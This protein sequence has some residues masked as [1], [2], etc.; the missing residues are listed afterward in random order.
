MFREDSIRIVDVIQFIWEHRAQVCQVCSGVLRQ[1]GR[2]NRGTE[3]YWI[4]KFRSARRLK[5]K[6]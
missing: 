4:P 3:F 6:G 2:D 1:F 5:G